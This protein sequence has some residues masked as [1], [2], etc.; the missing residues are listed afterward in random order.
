MSYLT[1]RETIE[2]SGLS[3]STI[4]N[5]IRRGDWIEG[6]HFTRFSSRKNLFNET[7]ITDW[8]ANRHDPNAHQ[9][10]IDNFVA[11]LPSNQPKTAKIVPIHLPKRKKA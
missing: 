8:I 2:R 9:R 11:G 5:L 4:K 3:R 1:F 7:L 10:A 6:I